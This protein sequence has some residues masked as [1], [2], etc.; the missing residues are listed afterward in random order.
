MTDEKRTWPG[1]AVIIVCA[2]PDEAEH[3]DGEAV[4]MGICRDCRCLIAYRQRT[5]RRVLAMPERHGRPVEFFCI[6]CAVQHDFGSLDV[7]QDHRG[8]EVTS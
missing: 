1:D 3:A 8:M 6:A 5:L 7:V 2:T 4:H